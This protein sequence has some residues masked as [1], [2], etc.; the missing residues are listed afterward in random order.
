MLIADELRKWLLDYC[1]SNEECVKKIRNLLK[2]DNGLVTRINVEF[3][4]GNAR[5]VIKMIED[6]IDEKNLRI[7]TC[8]NCLRRDVAVINPLINE[9]PKCS[10]CKQKS[11]SVVN[12]S[13]KV[14][15]ESIDLDRKKCMYCGN[16][17]A[18]FSKMTCY[19]CKNVTFIY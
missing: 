17:V 12:S 5:K 16:P 3:R 9:K 13:L 11:L 6:Y 19:S 14:E 1:F 18:P 7:L 2:Q 10:Y 4:K 8:N 15:H